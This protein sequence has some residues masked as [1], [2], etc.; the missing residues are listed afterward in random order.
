MTLVKATL[1]NMSIAGRRPIPVLVNPDNYTIQANMSYPDIT[2]PGLR[3]PLLQFVRGEA[4][5]LAVELFLD[6]SNSGESLAD[7]LGEI[8]EFVTINSELHAPPVCRLQ[9]GDINF[10]GVMAEYQE[11]F[12]MFDEQGHILRARLTVKLKAYEP[13]SLQVTEINRQSPDRTKM[14]AVRTGDRYDLIAA[15]EYG[16]PRLWTVIAAANGDDRPRRLTP[17]RVIEVPPL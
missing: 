12:T 15:E 10:S 5:T 7:K 3:L 13:A 2:V 8:R 14:R 4:K 1:T 9:W 11:K 6:R 17:G 16:D